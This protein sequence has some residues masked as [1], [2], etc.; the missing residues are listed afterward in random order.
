MLAKRGNMSSFGGGGHGLSREG[1]PMHF[2]E[3]NGAPPPPIRGGSTGGSYSWLPHHSGNLENHSNY[4]GSSGGAGGY[5]SNTPIP[6]YPMMAGQLLAPQQHP[7][8]VPNFP[9]GFSSYQPPGGDGIYESGSVIYGPGYSNYCDYQ[10]PPNSGCSG[11]PLMD[12]GIQSS[13]PSLVSEP[14]ANRLHIQGNNPQL[15]MDRGKY[16]L[17]KRLFFK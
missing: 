13:L 1:T 17:I 5:N 11:N 12:R 10:S 4:S 2:S 3:N 15:H 16:Y 6:R 14:M 8:P 9:M 7:P